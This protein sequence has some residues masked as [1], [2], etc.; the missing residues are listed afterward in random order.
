MACKVCMVNFLCFIWLADDL[1]KNNNNKDLIMH[2]L[3]DRNK[4]IALVVVDEP[5]LQF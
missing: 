2:I 1:K 3:I 5:G 4:V